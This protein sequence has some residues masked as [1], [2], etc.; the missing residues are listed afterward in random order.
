MT[1]SGT[2]ESRYADD[3][4]RVVSVCAEIIFRNDANGYTVAEFE[5]HNKRESEF[6]GVGTMP[7]LD[8]G[9]TVVLFG[10]WTDHPVYGRQL[11]VERFSPYRATSESDLIKYLS[12][13][14]V[15][16]IG[17]KTA[18]KIVARFGAE[19]LD[20][21][22]ETPEKL[23]EIRGIS[24]NKAKDISNVFRQKED[25]QNLSLLLAP[26]GFGTARIMS[27]YKRFG[28]NAPEIIRKNPY[29]LVS[30]ISGIGFLTADRLACSLGF[31]PT[32]PFRVGS[33]VLY[34]LSGSE[35]DG[36]TYTPIDCLMEKT[37]HLL[38][39]RSVA[40]GSGGAEED[41]RIVPES[42]LSI[43]DKEFM[44]GMQFLTD[45]AKV[46]VYKTDNHEIVEFDRVRSVHSDIRV[47]L[48]GTYEAEL[49]V[50]SE[51]A[52]K[53][54]GRA[55]ER[56]EEIREDEQTIAERIRA[57]AEALS[58]QLSEEQSRALISAVQSPGS[59]ITG[60]PGTGKTTIV[61]V[62]VRY[63]EEK[64]QKVVLCAPT[65]RAA[66][67]LSEACGFAAGTIHRLLEVGH[68]DRSEAGETFFG[69]NE[70][71]PIEADVVIVDETSMLDTMLLAALLKALPK[72]CKIVF[73]GDK[74][75]LPSVGAGNVLS[76]IILSGR[77]PFV[78]LRTIYRQAKQSRIVM[79]AHAV[80]NGESMIFDQS[81]ESD[82]MLVIKKTSED[83][84][85]AVQRLYSHVLPEVYHMNPLRDA[86]VLCPSRKGP[87]G[88]VEL[89]LILQKE[90]GVLSD[91]GIKSKGFTFCV[92]DRVMQ[93]RNDY[94][95]AYV[96]ADG[97]TGQGVF[98]GELGVVLRVDKRGGELT[99]ELDDKRVVTYD[100]EH[101]EDLEPAYA[102]T[103]HKSQGSEFPVVIL[104]V[105]GGP[106]MLYNR[107]LLYTAITRA[108]QRLFVVSDRRTL[109]MMIRNRSQTE[110]NT[111]L[112]AFL[113]ILSGGSETGGE[114][115]S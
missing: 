95:L 22:R 72:A 42:D 25:F 53:A 32:S 40:N 99:V 3:Q 74:D 57:I 78:R 68:P 94:E 39:K 27:V 66:K 89:N 111:S 36:N 49:S 29:L 9:E 33:A 113:N 91:R 76:D 67:R 30:E 60:G 18:Q 16:W 100:T 61:A 71:N 65:G 97:A 26:F 69:R 23:I 14:S 73:I 106:P 107:N 79:S 59:V 62:L 58:I 31:D 48:A 75:Q 17:P 46:V 87:A 11:Q 115:E 43:S 7:F 50:A 112:K 64:G 13:G 12:S 19:T 2:K 35:N 80:L 83:I 56:E 20:V 70:E 93:T 102:I 28:S 84:A 77:L 1:Y 34:V 47:A 51:L 37:L 15:P 5:P 10:K 96:Q 81:I 109:A 103:V 52:H 8:P 21:L 6:T 108:K 90:Y 85:E 55:V 105:P 44:E 104:A 114:Q 98:N 54:N 38:K 86:V 4:A 110:R 82:C 41:E 88:I 63:F 101:M 45:S 24:E 92:G